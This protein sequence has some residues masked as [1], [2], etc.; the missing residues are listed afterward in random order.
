[1]ALRNRKVDLHEG[2]TVV[3]TVFT[4]PNC[5]ACDATKRALDKEGLEYLAIDATED[6]AAMI[7]LNSRGVKEMPYVDAGE[8]GTWTGFR[9][10]DIKRVAKAKVDRL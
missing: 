4:K 3:I 6:A 8:L 1:M 5:S 10:A 2:G 7:L 9:Y